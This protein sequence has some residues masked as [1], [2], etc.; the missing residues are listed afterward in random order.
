[1]ETERFRWL[2]CRGD[3]LC[4]CAAKGLVSVRLPFLVP[5]LVFFRKC[6]GNILLEHKG[7]VGCEGSF[8]AP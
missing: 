7:L 3:C 8:H 1:M 5:L 2:R 4:G 6:V